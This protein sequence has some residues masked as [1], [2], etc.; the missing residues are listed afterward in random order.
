M[1]VSLLAIAEERAA[2]P[3]V[4]V[5]NW[6]EFL[7]AEVPGMTN[8]WVCNRRIVQMRGQQTLTY[9]DAEARLVVAGKEFVGMTE[10]ELRA[11]YL[12]QC[13]EPARRL[14]WSGRDVESMEHAG[15]GP[16]FHQGTPKGPAAYVDLRHAYWQVI[17][18]LTTRM[19]YD[20][21]SGNWST[22]GQPWQ[23]GE[24]MATLKTLYASIG[25]HAFRMRTITAQGGKP[26]HNPYFFPQAWAVISDTLHAVALEAVA[27]FG[28]NYVCVDGAWVPAEKA[29]EYQ[30]FLRE[31]WALESRVQLTWDP[32]QPWA[33]G[34]VGA[35]KHANWHAGLDKIRRLD[36]RKRGALARCR[37]GNV[38]VGVRLTVRS[39]SGWAAFLEHPELVPANEAVDPEP[40]AWE[41]RHHHVRGRDVH[42]AMK[43]RAKVAAAEGLKPVRQ[44]SSVPLSQPSGSFLLVMA[45]EA[46]PSDVPESRGP[47]RVRIIL[48]GE[49]LEWMPE[50]REIREKVLTT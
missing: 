26:R 20:F 2:R 5:P 40:T 31:R 29:E 30:L 49:E 12:R 16:M 19:I 6:A 32:S 46:P 25:S 7:E 47:P 41:R 33:Y 9:A 18:P 37:S 13:I 21:G 45:H 3:R 39:W 50:T 17:E 27:L 28:A 14:M 44:T 23:D 48:D 4:L 1:T 24:T 34:V 15:P 36:D 11:P 35:P 43:R 22:A 8:T 42:A 10:T 38:G